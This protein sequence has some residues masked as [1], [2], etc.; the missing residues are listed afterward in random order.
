M[1][2]RTCAAILVSPWAICPTRCSRHHFGAPVATV[3]VRWDSGDIQ[4]L[5]FEV[6]DD[7]FTS[8]PLGGADARRAFVREL[9]AHRELRMRVAKADGEL[10]SDRFDLTGNV[11]D[12]D[13]DGRINNTPTLAAAIANLECVGDDVGGR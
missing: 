9:A 5:T 12:I 3:E 1:T 13:L 2:L 10:V 4:R 7:L 11:S 8:S 6:G